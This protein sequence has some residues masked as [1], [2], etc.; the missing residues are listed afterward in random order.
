MLLVLGEIFLKIVSKTFTL[1]FLIPPDTS[2]PSQVQRKEF[3]Q[4]TPKQM[5]PYTCNVC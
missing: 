1:A 2:H 3:Y 4:S 5:H